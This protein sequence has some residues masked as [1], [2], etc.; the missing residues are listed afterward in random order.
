VVCY[1]VTEATQARR[2]AEVANRAKDEFLAMLG[3]ELRNP[4][5]P[6]LTAL[7]LLRLRGV[8]AGERE[9]AIIE[10]QVKHLVGL[11]DDLLDVSRITR[12]KIQIRRVRVPVSGAIAKAIETSSPLLEQKAHE[13]RLEL[14]SDALAVNG[15]P[16][17]LAQ[18]ISNLLTN[19]A[20]YT[21]DGGRITIGARQEQG[22]VLLT[23][24]D[25]GIGIAPEML[26]RI[27]DLFVQERQALDR[28]Q[29]G[30]GLGLAI[31]KSL[32]GLH[33]GSVEARSPGIGLGSR[34]G[35]VDRDRTD[36]HVGVADGR[37][38]RGGGNSLIARRRLQAVV[39]DRGG[40]R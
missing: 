31:V 37:Q 6:I 30:L 34:A 2:E 7:H 18:V 39:D 40:D 27:F 1:D 28:A 13:L 36:R 23:V 15:D 38:H 29:G 16:D 25:T 14:E 8:E 21:E 33:G 11:V 4:L 24:R 12:G 19:A 32:V 10:R 20:K 26:P 35:G 17:R 9:R 3:H 22:E 5:A